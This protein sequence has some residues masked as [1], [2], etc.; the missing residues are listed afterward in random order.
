MI[1]EKQFLIGTL[2]IEL[3]TNGFPKGLI[4]KRK[5]TYEECAHIAKDILY[6]DI[7][8]TIDEIDLEE[9]LEDYKKELIY[10]VTSLLNGTFGDR[11]FLNELYC[12][13]DGGIGIWC[14]FPI[15][16]YLQKIKAI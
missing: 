14:A 9:E 4:L 5:L 10:N 7:S 16:E 2:K 13:G 8:L 6:I 12:D 11:T 1:K 15:V 3:E